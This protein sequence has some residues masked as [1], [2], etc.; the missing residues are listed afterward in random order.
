MFDQILP[1]R[2][3]NTYRGYKFALWL[4][5]VVVVI[6]GG[7]R[8]EA[9]EASLTLQQQEARMYRRLMKLSHH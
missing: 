2:A 6:A 8:E 1:L 5:A 9:A 7:V 3:D 4:F